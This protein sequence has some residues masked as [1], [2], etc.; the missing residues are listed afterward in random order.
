MR[1]QLVVEGWVRLMI[2]F[3]VV[4]GKVV[5]IKIERVVVWLHGARLRV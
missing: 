5:A 2:E 3:F 1:V 4:E